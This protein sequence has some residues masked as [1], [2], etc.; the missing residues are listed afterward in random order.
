MFL[1]P[2]LENALL[3]CFSS[4]KFLGLCHLK[5]GMSVLLRAFG[6]PKCF[7]WG[8]DDSHGVLDNYGDCNRL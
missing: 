2:M 4:L 6:M 1:L 5:P 7:T 3:L 8:G